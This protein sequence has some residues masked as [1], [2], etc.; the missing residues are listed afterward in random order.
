MSTPQ[1]T[2]MEVR[3][4]EDHHAS[5][6][7][8]LRLL[9]ATTHIE[10]TIR[11]RLREQFDITLPRFDLMAQLER[12]PQ[13][14]TMGEI[15]R[16]MMVTGGNVTAIVDQLEKEQLVVRQTLLGDRRIYS[17]CLTPGGHKTFAAMAKAHETWVVELLAA[18]SERQQSQLYKLLGALK[19]GLPPRS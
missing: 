8:W 16:R 19:L 7:L 4:H 2:D 18:L 5:L 12:E 14:L 1:P 9:S 6:R 17:V 15:S 13:G 11:Q 10:D 3:A